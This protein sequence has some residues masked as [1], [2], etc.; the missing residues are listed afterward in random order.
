[1]TSD[2]ALRGGRPSKQAPFDDLALRGGS[3]SKQVPFPS[4]PAFDDGELSAVK[5]VIESRRWW[6]IVGSQV[7]AFEREFAA[8]QGAK[9]AV[10]VTNGTQALEIAL[11]ADDIGAGDE[12]IVPAFTFI[13][14]AYAPLLVNAVPILVDVRPDN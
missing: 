3:P 5:E 7:E 4:W 9:G 13:S 12:V 1:M 14:T 2:L 10:A 6:R 11:T 8:Y